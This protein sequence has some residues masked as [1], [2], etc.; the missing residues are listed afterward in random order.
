MKRFYSY[1]N[2]AED[3]NSNLP[4]LLIYI[5]IEDA[6]YSNLTLLHI[7]GTI[8]INLALLHINFNFIRFLVYGFALLLMLQVVFVYQSSIRGMILKLNVLCFLL[9]VCVCV[10]FLMLML[11]LLMW[12]CLMNLLC[13]CMNVFV[14]DVKTDSTHNWCCCCVCV[15]VCLN[16]VCVCVYV[17]CCVV[18]IET[19][20]AATAHFFPEI[21]TAT[22]HSSNSWSVLCWYDIEQQQTYT[23]LLLLLCMNVYKQLCV[24]VCLY[25]LLVF[26]MNVCCMN[27]CIHIRICWC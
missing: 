12:C 7:S 1:G 26:G 16:L 18:L 20:A 22:T 25:R 5:H 21:W 9:R 19:V 10:N 2:K 15:N 8:F 24:C 27:V 4:L 11:L 6:C 17:L 14:W 3:W 23:Q 13:V